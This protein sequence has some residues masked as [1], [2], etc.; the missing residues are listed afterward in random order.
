MSTALDIVNKAFEEK[1]SKFPDF[2]PGDTVNVHIRIKEGNKERIQQ[3]QG[4]VLQRKNKG[5]AGETFTVRKTSGTVAVEKVFPLFSPGIEKVELVRKG[6]VR[7]SR[8]FYL[9]H[10]KG[11]KARIKERR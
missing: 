2:I 8:I 10:A 4:V 5:S 6:K 3:F 9:R 7:Q 1:R 11:K